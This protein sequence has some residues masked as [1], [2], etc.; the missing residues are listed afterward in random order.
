MLTSLTMVVAF[1]LQFGTEFFKRT[2]APT[3]L[4]WLGVSAGVAAGLV[5]VLACG[6]KAPVLQH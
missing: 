6:K 4:L 2:P 3:V 1:W 5:L